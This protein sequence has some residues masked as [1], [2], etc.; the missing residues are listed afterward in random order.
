[1][2]LHVYS[3]YDVKS[4]VFDRLF[5]LNS[6]GEA[7]RVFGDLVNNKETTIGQHPEDF[8]LYLF[9][10][11]DNSEGQLEVTDKKV[12]ISGPEVWREGDIEDA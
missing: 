2:M 10:F 5:C 8:V 6:D 11:F 3:I 12:I 4:G 1:M 7:V 9:G